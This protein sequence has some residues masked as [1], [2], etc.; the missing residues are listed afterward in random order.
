MKKRRSKKAGHAPPTPA[1]PAPPLSKERRLD[2]VGAKEEGAEVAHVKSGTLGGR[3][4]LLFASLVL[5]VAVGVGVRSRGSVL[6]VPSAF[7]SAMSYWDGSNGETGELTPYFDDGDDGN[8]PSG[9]D[10]CFNVHPNGDMT[11]TTRACK[12]AFENVDELM[13]QACDGLFGSQR[14]DPL[15]CDGASGAR[16]ITGKGAR[17]KDL[18]ADLKEGDSDVFL[19][20]RH[21]LFVWPNLKVG[22]TFT[23]VSVPPHEDGT[24]VTLEQMS[25][26]PRVFSVHNFATDEE[27]KQIIEHNKN[28][29]TPSE[30]GFAGK[31]GDPTRNSS[32]S[33]DSQSR[34]ARALQRRAFQ[35][36]ALDYDHELA[37]A[38]Q[39]LRYKPTEWYKPHCDYFAPTGYARS[40][41]TVKNGTNRF[42]TVFLYLSNV[43]EGGTTVF[44]HSTSHSYYK[45]GYLTHKG[46]IKTASY[47]AN[48]DAA[49]VCNETSEALRVPAKR[50]NAVIF[51]SQNPDSSLDPYSLHGG[52]PV[53]KGTKWSA[54]IWIWNRPKASKDEA[55]DGDDDDSSKNTKKP[56]GQFSVMFVND[57]SSEL[58]LFWNDGSW[59]EGESKDDKGLTSFGIVEPGEEK[60]M[61]TFKSHIFIGRDGNGKVIFN[62]AA[63]NPRTSDENRVS[64]SESKYL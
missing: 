19:V 17:I 7:M 6:G 59:F 21:M 36:L 34:A 42:V 29:V 13:E 37:G 52:C 54:N 30:V 58:E 20:P 4:G 33:W 26:S 31:A 46:T 2:G 48:K 41:P 3:N 12:A 53:T 63:T 38:V 10:F 40:D 43:E 49:W 44:P 51:Y 62:W 15:A 14:K 9:D 1:T 47:I 11:T 39:V 25:T 61:N 57:H 18:H 16:L 45:G 22:T 32:T 56:K 24:R 50:G 8:K 27:I 5:G 23:P 35:A 64:M 55:L 28:R 60:V